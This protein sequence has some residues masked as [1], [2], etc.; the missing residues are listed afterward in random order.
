MYVQIYIRTRLPYVTLVVLL[1]EGEEIFKTRSSSINTDGNAISLLHDLYD[2]VA[3]VLLC[4]G[5]IALWLNAVVNE[6]LRC[7]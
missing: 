3:S 6:N 5:V 7:L 2:S 1:W 4:L